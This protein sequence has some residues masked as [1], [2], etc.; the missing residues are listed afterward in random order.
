MHRRL[1]RVSRDPQRFRDLARFPDSP[2]QGLQPS[3]GV[4]PWPP[5]ERDS[6]PGY[7][8]QRDAP[9]SSWK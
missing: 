4:P 5:T 9:L 1:K 8:V 6:E 7:S 3:C 2:L